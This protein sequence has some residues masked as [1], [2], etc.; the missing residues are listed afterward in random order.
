MVF[1]LNFYCVTVH[2]LYFWCFFG[3]GG[4]GEGTNLFFKP[5]TFYQPTFK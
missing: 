5:E 3:Y 4:C 2:T 1:D